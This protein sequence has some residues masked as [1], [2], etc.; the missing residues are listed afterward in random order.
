LNRHADPRALPRLILVVD[1]EPGIRDAIGEA[2]ADD[3]YVV[4]TAA[5]GMDALQWLRS[6]ETIP[7][8]SCST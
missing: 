4:E 1:D 3:G 7:D 8:P 2:L 6:A 5:N